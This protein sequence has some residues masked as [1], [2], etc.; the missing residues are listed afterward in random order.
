MSFMNSISP[1][2]SQYVESKL[3]SL[4][5]PAAN[6][7]IDVLLAPNIHRSKCISIHYLC[8]LLISI[9]TMQVSS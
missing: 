5:N 1:L 8:C 6:N 7:H 4:K 9:H 2:K 3:Q